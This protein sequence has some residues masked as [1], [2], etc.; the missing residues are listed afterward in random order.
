MLFLEVA[1]TNQAWD[2]SYSRGKWGKEG[3]EESCHFCVCTA[4]V[5]KRMD[6]RMREC[7]RVCIWVQENVWTT[8]MILHHPFVSVFLHVF[9]LWT[10]AGISTREDTTRC[11]RW[12]FLKGNKHVIYDCCEQ[13]GATLT[14]SGIE[15]GISCMDNLCF[16]SC[17]NLTAAVRLWESML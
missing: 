14:Q 7:V 2:F 6:D 10:I 15:T 13:L 4:R 16:R 5:C 8:I 17:I 9:K 11:T 1:V 3:G 12:P